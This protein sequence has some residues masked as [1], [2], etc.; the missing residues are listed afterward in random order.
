MKSSQLLL[1]LA[2]A[3]VLIPATSA[4]AQ[5]D[6]NEVRIKV[7]QLPGAVVQ[8][9]KTNCPTCVIDKASRE[10]ENGVTVYDIEF[11]RGQGEIALTEDGFVVDRETV[12][13]PSEIPA[14]ALA[15]IRSAGGKIRQIVKDQVYA[16]L[17]DG[18]VIKLDAPKYL[19]E[20]DL[21]K[22]NQVAEIVASAEGQIVEAPRWR[23][24]GTPEN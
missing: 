2:A 23:K 8:S 16:E 4:R 10:V 6:G 1:I 12:A 19:Y 3:L 14:P 21:V 13:K 9:I 24:K 20:A 18:N 17:K 7:S 11:K 15:A 22:G 5:E